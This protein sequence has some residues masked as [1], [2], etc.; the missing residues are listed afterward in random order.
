MSTLRPLRPVTETSGVKY[1]QL[2]GQGALSE[3]R[4]LSDADIP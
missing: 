3:A 1:K 2:H 4:S